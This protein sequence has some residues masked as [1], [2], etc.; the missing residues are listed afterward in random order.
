MRILT[1]FYVLARAMAFVVVPPF[2]RGRWLVPGH[3]DAVFHVCSREV[4]ARFRSAEVRMYPRWVSPDEKRLELHDPVIVRRP[5][6]WDLPKLMSNLHYF[7]EVQQ[8]GILLES[9]R[10]VPTGDALEVDWSISPT[11]NGTVVLRRV[12]DDA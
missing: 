10:V 4:S 3:Q 1:A 2:L 9:I 7:Q 11:I 6:L 5:H 12:E 8:N